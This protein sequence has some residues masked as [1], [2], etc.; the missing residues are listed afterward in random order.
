[1]NCGDCG[2]CAG[3]GSFL[4]LTEGEVQMLKALCQFAFL[5]VARKA[6]DMVP[7]Y[8]EDDLYSPAEYSLILQLLERK[9]LIS[10]DY[11]MPIGAYSE[12]YLPYPVQ[13]S[14]ALTQRGQMVVEQ[15]DIWGM[16]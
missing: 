1:M 2:S 6:D 10:I 13:G 8:L 7:M 16:E 4:E 14:F 9:R 5:P 15:L 3:C 12:A 11:D